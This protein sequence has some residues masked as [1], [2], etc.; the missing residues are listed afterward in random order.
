MLEHVRAL[1]GDK[2]PGTPQFDDQSIRR[3]LDA[4]VAETNTINSRNKQ[5]HTLETAPE[6]WMACVPEG[7]AAFCLRER[8]RQLSTSDAKRSAQL[9]SLASSYSRQFKDMAKRVMANRPASR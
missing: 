1:L 6:T 2:D 3:G 8:S 5:T 7:A 9:A 4:A